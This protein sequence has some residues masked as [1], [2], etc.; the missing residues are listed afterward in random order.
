MESALYRKIRKKIVLLDYKPSQV[1]ILR[2]L[3]NQFGTSVTPVREALIRLETDGLV[4]MIP[5]SSVR[6][7]EI[8]FQG[9]K[10]VF[11][12]RLFLV[13]QVGRLAAQ[14]I[15]EE[16][17]GRI[18]KL[19]DKMKQEEDRRVL[20][21]LDSELHELI[22]Q[23]TK[24]RT[25]ARILETLRNRVVRLWFFIEDQDG[26]SK[27]MVRDF[28]NLVESLKVRDAEGSERILRDHV[29]RFI[30]QVKEAIFQK[31]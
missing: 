3:A 5:N 10:D 8:S 4:R 28:E 16:E 1:L 2:D 20:I 12:V 31:Q 11:E 13:G 6:V 14:R 7:T 23:A 9:L 17:L 27:G 19:L 30:E 15:T 22:N 25:L 24:N 29:V 18:K 26:Y 21:Q